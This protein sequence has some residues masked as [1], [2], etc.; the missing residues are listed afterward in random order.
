[1]S[2]K[3]LPSPT[4]YIS[5]APRLAADVAGQGPLILFLHGI[6]GNRTNWRAQ[7]PA[8]SD[9]YTAVALDTRG[10]GG[11]DDWDG[12]LVYEVLGHD[13]ARVLDDFGQREAH[14]VGLSMGGRIAMQFAK[15]YP[16][17]VSSLTLVDTHLSFASLPPEQRRQ[18]VESR[19]RPLREGK[20]LADIAPAVARNLVGPHATQAMVQQLIESMQALHVD[21]YLKFLHA[22]VEQDSIGD[23]DFIRAPTHFVV[24]EYDTLTPPAL[25]RTMAGQITAAPVEVT[26]IG[27]AGHLSNIE[28]PQ[29]F[30]EAVRRF[31][32]AAGQAAPRPS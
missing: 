26:V 20:T 1:M 3:Q 24:G 21:S 6:G 7:L 5:G 28:N 29:A 22:T 17:R 15:L 11:S 10:Y 12:P 25:T 4:R 27:N 2:T 31:I 19:S 32:D 30:N 14:L 9:A 23:L 16:D 13:I 18:F 8:F